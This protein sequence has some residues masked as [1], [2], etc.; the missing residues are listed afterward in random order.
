MAHQK[1]QMHSSRNA[2]SMHSLHSAF[3]G[4]SATGN[5]NGKISSLHRFSVDALAG[6]ASHSDTSS[7]EEQLLN[8][9]SD[10]DENSIAS[11]DEDI[12]IDDEEDD[13]EI[14]VGPLSPTAVST[15]SESSRGGTSP[16]IKRRKVWAE[17]LACRHS[18]TI[19][20]AL[21]RKPLDTTGQETIWQAGFWW[22]RRLMMMK[23]CWGRHSD[24]SYQLL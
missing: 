15:T 20:K 24:V 7:K 4:R 16:A 17:M 13:E 22:R 23:K 6:T 1:L 14:D 8:V 12:G 10:D 2:S 5:G 21:F 3:G 19:L 9:T 18:L 11:W